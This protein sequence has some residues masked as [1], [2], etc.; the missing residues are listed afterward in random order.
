MILSVY[1]F[2]WELPRQRE[3]QVMRILLLLTLIL[4]G[5]SALAQEIPSHAILLWPGGAP[6][7]VGDQDEDRP[8]ITPYLPEA[9]RA[10][11]TSVVV[12]PG[13]GYGALM[14]DY[15]GEQIAQWLNTLGVAAFVLKYRLGPRYHHPAMLEDGQRAVRWVR[16]RVNDFG[17][18]PNRIGIWGFSAGGHLASTVGTHF[19][20]GNPNAPDP[21]DRVSCR[22]DFMILAYPVISF[23]TP[24]TH[25]GSMKNLLGEH[26]DAKLVASLSN[27][28]Q[29]TLGTPPTFLFHTN[30]DKGVPPENSVLFYLALRKAGVPAELH[31]YERGPHGV[32]L[33]VKD[34]ILS[35][36]PRRLADWLHTRGL[37][38]E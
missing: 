15:E 1:P 31:I 6:G 22:P 26:P 21:I 10:A 37:I 18:R 9:G 32:G 12:C 38:K 27:E 16:Y 11:G 33:A 14:M 4:N 17:L 30:E 28:L 20:A 29:V 13:G 36:W 5:G 8:S 23:T 35:S 25:Q 2:G 24:Y 7:A 19:D 3:S 34:P